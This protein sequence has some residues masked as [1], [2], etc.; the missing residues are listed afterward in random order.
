MSFKSIFL[1]K[2]IN[3][4]NRIFYLDF[5]KAF[6]IFLVAVGHVSSQTLLYAP[7]NTTNWIIADVYST[8]AKISIPIFMM[9]TGVLLF[10]RDYDYVGF[11]KK[12]YPRILIPTIF[13]LAMYVI[14][15]FTLGWVEGVTPNTNSIL[16]IG[17]F[18][19]LMF[20][21]HAG[22]LTHFW[23]VWLILS[24]YLI[25]PIINK[26]I[27]NS[28]FTEI[29]YFLILWIITC[30]VTSFNLPYVNIDLRYFAGP[31]GYVLLGYF[32]HNSKS[33]WWDKSWLWFIVLIISTALKVFITYHNSMLAGMFRGVDYYDLTTVAE[34]FSLFILFRNMNFTGR[35]K[36]LTRGNIGTCILSLSIFTFGIYL[37][38]LLLFKVMLL[39]HV[40]FA[41]MFSLVSIPVFSI[42]LLVVAWGIM[43]ILS[44]IPILRKVTGA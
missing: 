27:K 12:R 35:W 30:A 44:K 33:K 7:I 31:L 14:L 22:Y 37:S 25:I 3:F 5:L 26:W 11:I 21:G 20:L 43:I 18:I 40:N 41:G 39:Y 23:Y 9:I 10:N 16:S 13:W 28:D 32:L 24:L 6:C 42:L 36:F 8:I 2:D 29:K 4:K 34:A 17:K 15:G 19:F 1:P 38:H